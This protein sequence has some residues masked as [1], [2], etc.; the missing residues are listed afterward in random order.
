[1]LI[2]CSHTQ[3][4]FDLDGNA[5]N[6]RRCS[7]AP[8]CLW[9][10]KVFIKW[11]SAFSDETSAM[12]VDPPSRR[13]DLS[14][15]K[16]EQAFYWANVGVVMSPDTLYGKTWS[17]DKYVASAHLALRAAMCGRGFSIC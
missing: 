6:R 13:C 3:D 17:L 1:M 16:T 11:V 12:S 4:A 7:Q 10:P 8:R 15:S 9:D 2:P 14:G 5:R